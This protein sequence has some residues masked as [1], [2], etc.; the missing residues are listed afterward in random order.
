MFLCN[1]IPSLLSKVLWNLSFPKIAKT[2]VTVIPFQNYTLPLW[3][4]L[5]ASPTLHCGSFWYLN[6]QFQ[7]QKSLGILIEIFFVCDKIFML[8]IKNFILLLSVT[9]FTCNFHL[10]NSYINLYFM[11]MLHGKVFIVDGVWG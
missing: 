1:D 11:Y 9:F 10:L 3:S 8:W 5:C 6:I 7:I 2:A 4:F